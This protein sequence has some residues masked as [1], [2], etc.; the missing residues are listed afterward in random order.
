[1]VRAAQAPRGRLLLLLLLLLQMLGLGY[2]LHLLLHLLHLLLLKWWSR[3]VAELHL[4]HLLW[5]L[6]ML[7]LCCGTDTS[8]GKAQADANN[9][10]PETFQGSLADPSN[11]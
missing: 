4:L 10:V 9:L 8:L 1:V 7:G 2:V 3:L 5:L 6:E 11:R